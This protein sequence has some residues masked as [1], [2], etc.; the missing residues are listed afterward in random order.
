MVA[1]LDPNEDLKTFVN[2]APEDNLLRWFNFHLKRRGHPRKVK[3]FSSDIKDA[4]N[5]LVLLHSIAPT[6]VPRDAHANPDPKERAHLVCKYAAQLDCLKFVTP[7]DI[8]AGNDKLNLAF[9]AYLFNKYPG[10][11]VLNN[12]DAQKKAL[13][14]AEL[15]MRQKLEEEARQQKLRW[16]QEERERHEAW[17]KQEQEKKAKWEA[18]ELARKQRWAQEEENLRGALTSEQAEWR[19]KLKREEEE[20]AARH[21]K[22][23]QERH[24][25][26]EERRQA[27]AKAEEL[28][29]QE[30]A[31]RRQWEAEMKR[32]EHMLQEQE[33]KMKE[34]AAREEEERR[35]RFEEEQRRLEEEAQRRLEE[36]LRKREEE[37]ARRKEEELERQRKW[38]AEK[39]LMAEQQR[40]QWEAEMQQLK[41]QEE[42]RRLAEQQEEERIKA[43]QQYY[44]E[45]QAKAQQDELARQQAWAEYY[46]KQQEQASLLATASST[47]TTTTTTTAYGATPGVYITKL[48]ITVVRGRRLVR[49]DRLTHSDP[50]VA[51]VHNGMRQKSSVCKNTQDPVWNQ[52]F[53]F[54]GLMEHDEIVLTVLDREHL[55]K[56]KFMGEIRLNKTNFVQGAESWFPVKGRSYKRDKVHGELY[57]KFYVQK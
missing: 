31:R 44:A 55:K 20:R 39:H 11:E 47:T 23:E 48:N 26:E 35:R 28:R 33:L 15:L 3:N 30:E 43:W 41:N 46:R 51:L 14:E 53:E 8:L 12:D 18:E 10:L 42:Q 40:L 19:A 27:E 34:A 56:D 7:E 36:E 16:E 21:F 57:L 54:R 49:K 1:M 6:V 17:L 5:Y 37:E 32:K 38:E 50:Y 9:T 45:Q 13:E 4:E 2:V 24:R 22:E 29:L 52:D 25:R